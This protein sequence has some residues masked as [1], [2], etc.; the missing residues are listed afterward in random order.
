MTISESEWC[1]LFAGLQFHLVQNYFG[2]RHLQDGVAYYA[3]VHKSVW[4]AC[5]H[6]VFMPVTMLGFFIAVPVIFR[7]NHKNT[8]KLRHLVMA[9]YFG[10]YVRISP[11]VAL[12][13]SLYYAIPVHYAA[14]IS[15]LMRI[16]NFSQEAEV[17]LGVIISVVALFIQEIFGHYLGGDDASRI[18]AVY[19]AIIYAPYFSIAHIFNISN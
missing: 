14:K 6:S 16:K 15:L 5:I 8:I 4:N 2:M 7:L 19:N 3:E 1:A 12:L 10:I 13:F 9:F 11:L 18:E 17:A